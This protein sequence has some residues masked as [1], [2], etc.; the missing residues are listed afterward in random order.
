MHENKKNICGDKVRSARL[1]NKTAITQQD[2]S[3]RLAI[4]GIS[5]DR[6]AISKIEAGRRIVTDFE[7]YGLSKALNVPI[8]WLCKQEPEAEC[9]YPDLSKKA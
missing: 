8:D 5:I 9:S 6:T 7:L 1:R 2:L 4:M 3:A